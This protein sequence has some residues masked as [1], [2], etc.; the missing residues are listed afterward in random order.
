MGYFSAEIGKKQKTT[1]E[2]VKPIPVPEAEAEAE[3]GAEPKAKAE[4]KPTLKAG[5]SESSDEWDGD[6][7]RNNTNPFADM[8]GDPGA[9]ADASDTGKSQGRKLAEALFLLLDADQSDK[10]EKKEF[11]TQLRAKE[12]HPAVQALYASTGIVDHH[13]SGKQAK[14]L[15]DAIDA[16]HMTIDA[17]GKRYIDL[18]ELTAFCEN[19][20]AHM[21]SQ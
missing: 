2:T 4:E 6:D 3:A 9:V 1:A 19:H 14:K 10:L 7:L 18:A 16:Q 21:A 5:L 20:G 12:D 8:V 17:D 13:A 15:F 11:R